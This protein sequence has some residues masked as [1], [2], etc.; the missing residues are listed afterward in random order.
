M[1]LPWFY[2]RFHKMHHHYKAPRPFDDLYIHPLES[3]GYYLIFFCFTLGLELSGTKV[4]EPEIQ[5]LLGTASHFCE[6]VV[7]R[8]RTV[9]N[10]YYCIP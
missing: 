6:A 9:Q 7:L 1:H 4:Y 8:L 3:F 5:A 2:K 10:G